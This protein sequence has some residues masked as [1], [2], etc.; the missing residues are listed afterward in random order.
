MKPK[1]RTTNGKKKGPVKKSSKMK[2]LKSSKQRNV[3]AAAKGTA[4]ELSGKK[5][6]IRG[7]VQAAGV[8]KQASRDLKNA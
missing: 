4:V 1:P 7:Y 6:R 3:I 2:V 5:T 8:R